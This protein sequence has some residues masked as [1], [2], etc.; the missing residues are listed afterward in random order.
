MSVILDLN[1][2]EV[3]VD[4]SGTAYIPANLSGH[5]DT[6]APAEGGEVEIKA[7]EFETKGRALI[8]NAW[9]NLDR[10][11]VDVLPLLPADEIERMQE[12]ISTLP[13]DEDL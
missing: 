7:V 13:Q 9:V 8:G 6:W 2:S 3:E 4:Y 10:V 1:G 12:E 5:P 11:I